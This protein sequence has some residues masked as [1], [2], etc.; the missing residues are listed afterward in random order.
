MAEPEAVTPGGYQD[1]VGKVCKARGTAPG[2]YLCSG[3]EGLCCPQGQSPQLHRTRSPAHPPPVLISGSLSSRLWGQK[4]LLSPRTGG[5]SPPP[6]LTGPP[7]PQER[8][9]SGSLCSSHGEAQGALGPPVFSLPPHQQVH[10]RGAEHP[11]FPSCPV[12]LRGHQCPPP[13]PP[14]SV[15]VSPGLAQL[16]GLP[17]HPHPPEWGNLFAESSPY[18]CFF[19]VTRTLSA[20]VFLG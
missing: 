4:D 12:P 8:P 20:I 16:L 19:P 1:L 2:P 10:R 11:C 18:L 6:H 5:K 13:P 17:H 3:P 15:A 9:D 7:R 14:P